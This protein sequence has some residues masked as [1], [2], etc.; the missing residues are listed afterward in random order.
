MRWQLRDVHLRVVWHRVG[1]AEP[2]RARAALV[3]TGACVAW[4][5]SQAGVW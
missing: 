4:F 2:D 5:R 1:L 3:S